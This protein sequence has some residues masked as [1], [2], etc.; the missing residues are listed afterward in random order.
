MRNRF[1][2]SYVGTIPGERV[3]PGLLE[4]YVAATDGAGRTVTWP[5]TAAAERPWTATVVEAATRP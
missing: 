4:W 1:R 3:A 5:V 2:R